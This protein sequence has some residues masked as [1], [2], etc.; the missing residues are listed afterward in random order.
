M[1]NIEPLEKGIHILL[2]CWI[3]SH[4]GHAVLSVFYEKG[5]AVFYVP[6]LRALFILI[7]VGAW[8]RNRRCAKWCGIAAVAI[9][10]IQ[11]RFIWVREAYGALSIP[12]L[13]FDI[14]EVVVAVS[15]LIFFFSSQRERYLGR[16]NAAAPQ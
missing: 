1:K 14:L 2:S 15:Y 3:F 5:S 6:V 8:R 12:V 11:G 4:V 7:T 10:L 16:A 9:I 13:A